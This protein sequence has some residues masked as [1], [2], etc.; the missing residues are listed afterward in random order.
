VKKEAK[1]MAK[2]GL[3]KLNKIKSIPDKEF[4]FIGENISIK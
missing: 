4:E 1:L 3:T 2:I